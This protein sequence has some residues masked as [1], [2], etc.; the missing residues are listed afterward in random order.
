[1]DYMFSICSSLDTLDLSGWDTSKVTDTSSMFFGCNNLNLL[2]LSG[3]DMSNLINTLVM[4]D[5][6]TS[7]KTIRMVGCTQDTINKIQT[8]LTTD[9]IT[10]VTIVTE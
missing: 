9:G 2:D 4:F 5:G 1:M 7:L 8:Q 3:W 10:G 6:C